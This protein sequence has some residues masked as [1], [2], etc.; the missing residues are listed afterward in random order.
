MSNFDSEAH[1]VPFDIEAPTP[2]MFWEPLEFIMAITFMGLGVVMNAFVFGML[3]GLGVLW[4]AKYLKRGAKRGA[5]Q[6]F[7]WARG[8]ELDTALKKFKA[9]WLNDFIE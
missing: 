1:M 5:M 7:L 4:G 2:I 3:T 8:L 6:H 9:P